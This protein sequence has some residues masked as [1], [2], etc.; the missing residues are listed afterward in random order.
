MVFVFI[1]FIFILQAENNWRK[2]QESVE[3]EYQR[4]RE[5]PNA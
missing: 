5:N 3:E 4:E 2:V 1:E